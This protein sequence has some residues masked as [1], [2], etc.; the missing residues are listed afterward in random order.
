MVVEIPKYTVSELV[1]SIK[2]ILEGA[3]GYFKITG[4]ISGFKQATSGH[5]YFN[6]KDN[7][8]SISIVF[9]R[10]QQILNNNILLEDGLEV[11][12]LGRLTTY[13]D[14]SN[15]QIIVEKI[16]INGEGTLIK[17]IEERKKKL[18]EEGLFDKIIKNLYLK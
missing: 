10:S 12:I 3:F 13:K 18:E 15:Y 1:N 4:E 7:D 17:I 2:N 5:S 14:R 11:S 6:L 9:F 8:S 16:E